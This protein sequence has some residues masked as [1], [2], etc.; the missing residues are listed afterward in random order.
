M[1]ITVTAQDVPGWLPQW[2]VTEWSAPLGQLAQT[3]T[4]AVIDRAPAAAARTED[5]RSAMRDLL[6]HGSY[7]PTGR[8]KPASE[9]LVRAMEEGGLPV[10]NPAVDILNAVSFV[11]GIAISVVDLDLCSGESFTVR[12]GREDEE[13]VFNASGQTISLRD[14]LCLCDE[15]GP[16]ANA[17]KDSQRTKTHPGT[18][19]TL[20]ILWSPKSQAPAAEATLAW[21]REE[22]E[23]AAR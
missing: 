17:V 4:A 2:F 21:Y 8:G 16:C 15:A 13:Y 23:N 5:L 3:D 1:P 10:I 11:S 19:R 22:L 9:Y 7:K 20:Q 12:H 6:R 14:L 18:R